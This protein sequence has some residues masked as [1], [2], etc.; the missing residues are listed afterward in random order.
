MLIIYPLISIILLVAG[1]AGLFITLTGAETASTVWL[2]GVIVFGVFL[3]I[4]LTVLITLLT[5]LVEHE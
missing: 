1:G 3:L 2:Q 5:V 4:G